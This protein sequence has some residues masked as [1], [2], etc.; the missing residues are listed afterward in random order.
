M[1]NASKNEQMHS[2]IL[3]ST[4]RLR[5]GGGDDIFSLFTT[6][7]SLCHLLSKPRGHF[8]QRELFAPDYEHDWMMPYSITY[9]FFGLFFAAIV[10]SDWAVLKGWLQ[11]FVHCLLTNINNCLYSAVSA[12][13]A[14]QPTPPAY[15]GTVSSSAQT[16]P[17]CVNQVC[18]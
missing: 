9:A 11:S 3:R 5:R 1:R 18:Y 12:T 6:I 15:S 17:Q 14:N 2:V 7:C 13:L 16:P 4:K 8:Q 10:L